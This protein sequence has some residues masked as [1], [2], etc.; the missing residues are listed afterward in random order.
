MTLLKVPDSVG[1]WWLSDGHLTVN[2]SD[3]KFCPVFLSKNDSSFPRYFV[4]SAW[5]ALILP[6]ISLTFA[7]I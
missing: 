1:W 5:V 6:T 2:L 4:S 3:Q 7:Q